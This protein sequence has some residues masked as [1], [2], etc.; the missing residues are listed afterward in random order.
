MALC[1]KYLE[2]TTSFFSTKNILAFYLSL[3]ILSKNG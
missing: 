2:K 3:T 1:K